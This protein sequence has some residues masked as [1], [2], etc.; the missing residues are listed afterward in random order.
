MPFVVFWDQIKVSSCALCLWQTGVWRKGDSEAEAALLLCT[1]NS[2]SCID[3][4]SLGRARV[5]EKV[6]LGWPSRLGRSG[7]W[8][9]DP[10]FQGAAALWDFSGCHFKRRE[11]SSL[12]GF[13]SLTRLH[14]WPQRGWLNITDAPL[15]CH[16]R[17]RTATWCCC[18]WIRGRGSQH[19]EH[20]TSFSCNP[21]TKC[22][23]F[24][25]LIKMSISALTWTHSI[26]QSLL[27]L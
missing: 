14:S 19:S 7:M 8:V 16:Q 25:A 6:N 26:G 12:G 13:S 17:I 10:V 24:K 21:P 22:V 15:S 1:H 9:T 5:S 11:E 4:V 27:I 3:S 20:I 2:L 23:K 18:H